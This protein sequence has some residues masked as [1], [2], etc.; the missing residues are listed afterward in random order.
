MRCVYYVYHDNENEYQIAVSMIALMDGLTLSRE[1]IVEAALNITRTEGLR[2]VTMRAVAARFDVTPMALYRHVSDRDE[3]V[4]LVADRVGS[5]VRPDASSEDSWDVRARAWADAQRGTLREHP[6]LA[7]WLMGNGPAG[8]EAYRLLELLASAL[9]DGGFDDARVARGTALIMSWTFS[10]VAIEDQAD[11]R[12]RTDHHGDR[13][14]EFVAGLGGIDPDS[15]PM[16][17]RIGHEFF[18]LSMREIFDLGLESILAGL[19]VLRP[20][21]PAMG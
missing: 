15:H 6:G 1:G 3:L 14:R 10:R 12:L 20:P 21:E 19:R 9:S 16:A 18:T 8:A 2:A 5:L 17:T 4:R 11:E 7:A 13:A